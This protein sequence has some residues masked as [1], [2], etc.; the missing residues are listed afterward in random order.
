[1]RCLIWAWSLSYVLLLLSQCRGSYRD[2]YDRVITAFDYI[3]IDCLCITNPNN[4][5]RSGQ[6]RSIFQDHAF[7]CTSLIKK[8]KK[9]NWLKFHLTMIQRIQLKTLSVWWLCGGQRAP[10]YPNQLCPSS[11]THLRVTTPQYVRVMSYCSKTNDD[12]EMTS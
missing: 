3:M 5:L 4:T 12:F 8:K 11:R 6:K 10:H 9:K 7:K 2:N 1:M